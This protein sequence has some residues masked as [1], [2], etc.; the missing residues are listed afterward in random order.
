PCQSRGERED[1]RDRVRSDRSST[2]LA[3]KMTGAEVVGYIG[4]AAWLPQI[5]TWL[6]RWFAKPILNISIE[7]T[8]EIGFTSFGPIFNLRM[9]FSV[10]RKDLIIEGFELDLVHQDGEK[11][12]FR[13]EGVQ[14]D[15]GE[16]RDAVGIR[17]GSLTRH[18][19]PIALKIGTVLLVE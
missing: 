8:V 17:Q 1:F 19:K 6:Y 5:A 4:A 16:T 10:D 11:R 14:E 12:T 2:I 13:W 18:Q 7:R 15:L 9:A 3:R